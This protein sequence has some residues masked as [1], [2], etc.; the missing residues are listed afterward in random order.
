M[1]TFLNHPV[2]MLFV[3][4]FGYVVLSLLYFRSP[5]VVVI[6]PEIS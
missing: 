3:I 1:W 6:D 4:L 5:D 2:V